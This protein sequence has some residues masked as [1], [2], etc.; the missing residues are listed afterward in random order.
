MPCDVIYIKS[1]DEIITQDVP[2]WAQLLALGIYA[3]NNGR[4]NEVASSTS[5]VGRLKSALAGTDDAAKVASAWASGIVLHRCK[6]ELAHAVVFSPD[7]LHSLVVEA[8]V[9]DRSR[10]D[11]RRRLCKVKTAP[12][13]VRRTR[14]QS[15]GGVPVSVTACLARSTLV[16]SKGAQTLE[17][18]VRKPR[19]AELAVD[20][21][22]HSIWAR[23]VL[24]LAAALL[25]PAAPDYDD[26][27]V[28]MCRLSG[29][30]DPDRG[31]PVPACTRRGAKRKKK[32]KLQRE[33]QK[34][35]MGKEGA[36]RELRARRMERREGAGSP[37]HRHSGKY[38]HGG[39]KKVRTCQIQVFLTLIHQITT[40][41]CPHSLILNTH[42]ASLTLD[43]DFESGNN[44]LVHEQPSLAGSL[45][46]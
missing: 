14:Y 30:R 38:A 3:D 37:N 43:A 10:R 27:C 15:D 34:A 12:T 1:V 18:L 8:V 35:W 6:A 11:T 20:R 24:R 21:S 7:F 19:K 33:R 39:L 36:A 9:R 40:L 5:F 23:Y 28:L 41:F 2:P 46:R 4:A 44:R 13:P 25:D 45:W 17:L 32:Q 29:F 42:T 26:G 22:D 31:M 16:V